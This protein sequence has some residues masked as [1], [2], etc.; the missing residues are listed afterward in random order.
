MAPRD[1]GRGP[2]VRPANPQLAIY[3]AVAILAGIV[4]AW[5]V[6]IPA[7]RLVAALTLIAIG[8]SLIRQAFRFE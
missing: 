8:F 2:A 4:V 3:G 7:L 5:L 6:E 1:A